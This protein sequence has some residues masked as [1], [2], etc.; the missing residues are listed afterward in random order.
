MGAKEDGSSSENSGKNDEPKVDEISSKFFCGL[1]WA[2]LVE[3]CDSAKPCPSGT[4]AECEG[5]QSCFANSPCAEKEPD[6]EV[7]E[8]VGVFNFATMVG[9][10]PSF[11][12]DRK[13]MSRNVG[14][15]QSWS[16]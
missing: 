3:D 10:I 1:S 2:S 7:E 15:W 9:T 13:T 5:G 16:I 11:C 6:E 4:N 12:K 8:T 14:Y